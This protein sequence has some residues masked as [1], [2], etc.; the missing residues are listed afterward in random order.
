MLDC[1]LQ[2][3][4]DYCDSK[5]VV[6]SANQEAYEYFKEKFI[7][8]KAWVEIYEQLKKMNV[9]MDIRF[10]VRF[11]EEGG[12]RMVINIRSKEATTDDLDDLAEELLANPALKERLGR[13]DLVF[14]GKEWSNQLI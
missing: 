9:Q 8:K 11:H 1:H 12:N 10:I 7:E 6:E 2:I 5:V 13:T 14:F 3:N 4:R